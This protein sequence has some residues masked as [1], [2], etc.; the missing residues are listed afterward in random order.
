[1]SSAPQLK[2]SRR[3]GGERQEGEPGPALVAGGRD[4][5]LFDPASPC[6]ASRLVQRRR[7]SSAIGGELA[8]PLDAAR[9]AQRRVTTGITE[10]TPETV[11]EEVS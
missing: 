6:Q 3:L 2:V 5:V 7:T 10:R 4:A 8:S 1:M 9:R 11:T